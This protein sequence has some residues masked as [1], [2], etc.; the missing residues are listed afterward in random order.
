MANK[1]LLSALLAAGLVIGGPALASSASAKDA[2]MAIKEAKAAIKKAA[3]VDGE[4]R[5]SGKIVKKASAAASKKDYAKAVK[6]ADQAKLQGELGYKQAMDQK[7][8]GNP[9][10]LMTK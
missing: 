6:L 2:Q 4:W 1:T 3:S 7:N 5:D 8:A 10:Y 9:P